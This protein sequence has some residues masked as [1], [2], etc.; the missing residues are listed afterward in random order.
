M[1]QS[2]LNPQYTVVVDSF[3]GT[4]RELSVDEAELLLTCPAFAVVAALSQ[5]PHRHW[6]VHKCNDCSLLVKTMPFIDKTVVN[7]VCEKE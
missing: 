4:F 1:A 6:D 7:R 2:E 5:E 3:D